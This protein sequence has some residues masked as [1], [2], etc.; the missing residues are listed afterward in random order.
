VGWHT[1]SKKYRDLLNSFG[2]WQHS[3]IAVC[4]TNHKHI[5]TFLQ[6]QQTRYVFPSIKNVTS[7]SSLHFSQTLL[8]QKKNVNVWQCNVSWQ[9]LTRYVLDERKSFSNFNVLFHRNI[10]LNSKQVVRLTTKSVEAHH[11]HAFSQCYRGASSAIVIQELAKQ[12]CMWLSVWED[13][14]G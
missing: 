4:S 8:Q 1:I 7:H 11:A 12:C 9:Y 13:Y 10:K 14:G 5:H 6:T 3:Q 2:K